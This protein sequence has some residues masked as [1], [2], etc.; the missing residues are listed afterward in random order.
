MAK[1]KQQK[2]ELFE[3]YKKLLENAEGVFITKPDKITPNEVNEFRKELYDI[4]SKFHVVKNSIFKLALKE[5]G[6]PDIESLGHG[7]HAVLF[8]KEDIAGS[9][10]A[11]SAFITE[12]HLKEKKEDRVSVIGG[13][14]EG[15]FVDASTVQELA[16]MPDF[17]GSISMILGILD[18]AMSGVVNVLEDSTRSFVT[19]LDQAFE[20]E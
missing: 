20:Q 19:I 1:T 12:T 2:K 9:A 13:I 16:E 11:L 6:L 3:K 4:D 15:N 7:K 18:D 5:A 8:A 17:E 14:I 10:K